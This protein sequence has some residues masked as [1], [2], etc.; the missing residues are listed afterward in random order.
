MKN[1]LFGKAL[2][3]R[4]KSLL[5]VFFGLSVVIITLVVIELLVGKQELNSLLAEQSDS[6]LETI[7]HSSQVA[8]LSNEEIENVIVERLLNDAQLI[9][10][11]YQRGQVNDELL[12]SIA[13]KNSLNRIN[14]FGKRGEKLFSSHPRIHENQDDNYLPLELL[15]P[16]FNN[17]T[18]TLILGLKRARLEEG[19]RYVVAIAAFNNDAIVINI[20][21]DEILGFRKM[22]GFG[23]FLKIAGSSQLIE[24]VALQDSS[25]IIAGTGILDELE[26]INDSGFLSDALSRD[27]YSWRITENRN[28]NVFEAVHPFFYKGNLVGLFRLGLSLEPLNSF[29]E[30]TSQRLILVSIFLL[31]MGTVVGGYVLIRSNYDFLRKQLSA[32]ESFSDQIIQNV[33][34][35]IIVLNKHNVV[36]LVNDAALSLFGIEKER[37]PDTEFNSLVDNKK[38]NDFIRSEKFMESFTCDLNGLTK[39]LL[40]SK[41]Y[42]K[43]EHD[44]K[45]TVLVMKDLT[46]IKLLEEQSIR[47]ERLLAMGELASGVAH[48]IR[49][50][51][52]AIGTIVQQ[53][54]KDFEPKSEYEEYQS[55]TKLVREEVRRINSTVESFLKFAK[56][57]PVVVEKFK[58]SDLF[59]QLKLQYAAVTA[60][61]NIKLTVENDFGSDVNWDKNKM[62]QV[63][64]NLI[65]NAIDAIKTEGEINL[66]CK[67][68][69]HDLIELKVTDNGSGISDSDLKKIFNLYFTT[70][71]RGTGIG[72]SII[73]RII[74]QHN[75]TIS[76]ESRP[77]QGTTFTLKLPRDINKSK[78]ITA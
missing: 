76:V 51:L 13:K 49:N 78:G 28:L 44:E 57:E 20:D 71:A 69:S 55:L 60:E 32:A 50:P 53:L 21:A 25:G 36:T 70:K 15:S 10:L 66:I 59:D 6:Y 54:Q 73:Q 39:N 52:N 9:D 77:G 43:N 48:E 27:D 8:L 47:N 11:L 22:L 58:L 61:R 19:Y 74:Y 14:I 46:E 30:R 75:G 29:N 16:L 37:F 63:F 56:P 38:C 18:D 35:A 42:F 17:K 33:S 23:Q 31:I 1:K 24:Y 12:F 4:P 7:I 67:S 26:L 5:I 72:L 65:Q 41:S 40:V 45:N 2:L 64:L 62:L 34:D 68:H 3:I